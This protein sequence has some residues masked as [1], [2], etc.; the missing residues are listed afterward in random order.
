MRPGGDADHLVHARA[1]ADVAR[2]PRDIHRANHARHDRRDVRAAWEDAYA[3]E[4]FVQC[5]PRGSS[6]ARPTSLGANTALIGLAVDERSGR[7]VA[8]TAV[9]NLVKGT[10]GAAIQSAN[11][12]LGLHRIDWAFP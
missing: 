7:V 9:D 10:A 5:C 12:A 4:P 1:R 8:V 11:L 2:H 3:G 6:R